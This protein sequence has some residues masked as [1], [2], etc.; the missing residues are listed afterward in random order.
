MKYIYIIYHIVCL[1]IKNVEQLGGV[2]EAA[3][4]SKLKMPTL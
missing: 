3:M 4:H 2:D 1:L